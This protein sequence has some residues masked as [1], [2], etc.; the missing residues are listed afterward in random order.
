[1]RAKIEP[2]Y[3]VLGSNIQNARERR[4]MTQAQL[5]LSLIPP[6]T[7]ASIANVES[8]KQRVLAHTLAQLATSLSVEIRDLMPTANPPIHS[9]SQAEVERELRKKLN[10]SDPALKK[11][12]ARLSIEGARDNA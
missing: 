8:G 10:L 11:L 3:K 6:S 7:R 4:K 5:G 12:T 1:M 2:F 9:P